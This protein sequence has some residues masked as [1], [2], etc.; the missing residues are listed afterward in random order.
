MAKTKYEVT[1]GA[2]SLKPKKNL[3]WLK[4]LLALVIGIGLGG[5]S[6]YY[7]D[8][9][10]KKEDKKETTV[11]VVKE[12]KEEKKETELSID[13]ALVKK[14]I[15]EMHYVDGSTNEKT[16]YIEKKTLAKDLD[17]EYVNNLL[18]MEAYRNKTSYEDSVS[19]K[20]LEDARKSLFGK[21][22]EI[23]VP[24]DKEVGACPIFKYDSQN[25]TYSKS[26]EKCSLNSDIKIVYNTSKASIKEKEYINIYETV[27]FISEEKI[28][29]SIDGSNNLKF[30][31]KD[32]E[33]DEFDIRENYKELNQ[34]KYNFKYDKDTDNYVFESIELVK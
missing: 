18:M 8:N 32:I 15:N 29:K 9:Y 4:V 26:A 1:V 22:Y 5:G 16:L 19:V 34:Y 23:I 2:P 30:E 14:L 12:N 31:V 33:F 13:S 28:Y 17:S 21:N 6:I 20:N 7:Y 24:T 11:K 25:R 10:Y 3:T 27:A